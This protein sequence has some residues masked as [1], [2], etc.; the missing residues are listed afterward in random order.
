MSKGIGLL[1]LDID[2]FKLYNDH[3]GH[4]AGDSTLQ[5]VADTIEHSLHRKGD[6]AFR[7]GGEE[8]AVILSV[9]SLEEMESIAERIRLNIQKSSI[10]HIENYSDNVVTVSVGGCFRVY[11]INIPIDLSSMLHCADGKLYAA[12]AAGRNRVQV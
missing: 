12:K 4:N 7:I 9:D 11:N 1:Y 2:Y 8:F 5:K 10:E 6:H 3:Y